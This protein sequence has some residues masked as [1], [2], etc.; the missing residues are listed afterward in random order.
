MS[1]RR[2]WFRRWLFAI[3]ISIWILALILA[4]VYAVLW[5]LVLLIKLW[6]A[7]I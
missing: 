2:A 1:Q 5:L 4:G 3:N 6:E 7:P